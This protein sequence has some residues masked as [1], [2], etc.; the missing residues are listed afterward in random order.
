MAGSMVRRSLPTNHTAPRSLVRGHRRP[1][2]RRCDPRPPPALRAH[3]QHHR[4]ELPRRQSQKTC[5]QEKRRVTI[6]AFGSA[7]NP[8]TVVPNLGN[9]AVPNWEILHTLLKVFA[10]PWNRVHLAVES[11]FTFPWKPC[12]PSRGIRGGSGNR[13]PAPQDRRCSGGRELGEVEPHRRRASSSERNAVRR[14]RLRA[15]SAL[16]GRR[17][18]RAGRRRRG[19]PGRQTPGGATRQR[20]RG[21]GDQCEPMGRA[22]SA[23]C[24]ACVSGALGDDNRLHAESR[25]SGRVG[26]PLRGCRGRGVARGVRRPDPDSHRPAKRNPRARRD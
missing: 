9:Q 22:H 6:L 26:R 13:P 23:H 16:A 5:Q 12:S 10:F 19:H 14:R 21:G 17:D 24:S 15:R 1:R 2:D 18:R 20:V 4:R 25:S 7:G 11:V 3:D 8:F